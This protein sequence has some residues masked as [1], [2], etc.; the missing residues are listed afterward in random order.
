M[1]L[2]L[3]LRLEEKGNG[4]IGKDRWRLGRRERGSLERKQYD[5]ILEVKV[6]TSSQC[7]NP[8]LEGK[9]LPHLYLPSCTHH[10]CQCYLCVCYSNNYILWFYWLYVLSGA[11]IHILY[12]H[13]R[14][15]MWRG[16]Q[17][18]D[19][20]ELCSC[21]LFVLQSSLRGET[22]YCVTWV[23]MTHESRNRGDRPRSAEA[24]RDRA[25]TGRHR[26]GPNSNR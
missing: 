18:L 3:L 10:L 26:R 14:P 19:L 24:F 20:T 22:F 8:L 9:V 23:K 6:V 5:V 1:L 7:I 25:S 13:H 17:T 12:N 2:L 21:F 11:L 15:K 16:I 4:M